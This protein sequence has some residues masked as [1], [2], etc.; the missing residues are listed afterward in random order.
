MCGLKSIARSTTSIDLRLNG[1]AMAETATT[2]EAG[3]EKIYNNL[4][5]SGWN[6]ESPAT[7]DAK[8]LR[9]FP[10]TWAKRL[11]FGRDPRAIILSGTFAA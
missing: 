8:D 1:G 3:A 4:L 7:M 6:I 5:Q 9:R 2:L 11:A 10:T